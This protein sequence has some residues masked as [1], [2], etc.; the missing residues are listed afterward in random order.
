MIIKKKPERPKGIS[1]ILIVNNT[2][3]WL[4]QSIE[5]ILPLCDE[6][7]VVDKDN[8]TETKKI[9]KNFTSKKVTMLD[10][11][12]LYL[13]NCPEDRMLEKCREVALRNSNYNII[14]EWDANFLMLQNYVSDEMYNTIVEND[15][16]KIRGYVMASKTLN[17][18][19]EKEPHTRMEKRFWN[20][21]KNLIAR[22][23]KK[24]IE[25][26]VYMDTTKIGTIEKK[27]NIDA[28]IPKFFLKKKDEYIE[29]F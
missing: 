1:A 23:T 3:D 11:P 22:K 7:I 25:E 18:I 16:V 19:S 28:D 12:D 2:I 14:C 21:D 6:I 20:F 13:F 9:V 8:T 24:K 4:G 5:S 26:P 29:R 17:K 15:G 10:N 27:R